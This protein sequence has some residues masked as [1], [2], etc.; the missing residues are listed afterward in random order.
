MAAAAGLAVTITAALLAHGTS[1]K[2]FDDLWFEV[3]K[4][5]VQVVAVGVIGGALTAVWRSHSEWSEGQREQRSKVREELVELFTLYNDVKRV[6]R[7]LKS[8]G[9]DLMARDRPDD[10]G[11]GV[12]R[13]LTK[14]QVRVFHEQMALLTNAQLGFESKARQFG[15]T[16]L[17]GDDTEKV[18]SELGRIESYLHQVLAAAWERR[19]W[20]VRTGTD[21][22]PVSASLQPLF[23]KEPFRAHMSRPLRHL[24]RLVNEQLFG[25]ATEATKKALDGVVA[26]DALAEDADEPS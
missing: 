22:S 13:T 16:D 10:T 11:A 25:P 21:L 6:R 24:T 20:T 5:G 19:G 23:R 15:Q 14:E 9:L 2:W 18:V 26:T 3:A 7:T 8:Q 1:E 12:G 17:L 4:A